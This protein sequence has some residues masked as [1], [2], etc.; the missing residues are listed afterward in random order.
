MNKNN[1]TQIDFKSLE[2]SHD[3]VYPSNRFQTDFKPT[4]EQVWAKSV[5]NIFGHFCLRLH[6][7]QTDWNRFQIDL[8]VSCE[9][10]DRVSNRFQIDL[11]QTYFR[12]GLKYV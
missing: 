3:D 12:V 8:K 11:A 7:V 10:S 6:D 2:C 1:K 5:W 4:F 9:P